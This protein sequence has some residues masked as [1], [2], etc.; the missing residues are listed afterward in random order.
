MSFDR[1]SEIYRFHDAFFPASGPTP[2][3][4]LTRSTKCNDGRTTK[5]IYVKDESV[6]Y[7]LPAFKILGASWGTAK[8]LAD[9]TGVNVLHFEALR[10]AARAAN[11]KVYAATDGNHGRAVARTASRLGLQAH[12]VVPR[13]VELWSQQAIAGEGCEVTVYD[14]DYDQAVKHAAEL[15]E[16]QGGLLVQDTSWDGYETIPRNI[17][18]G[19]TRLFAEI[20]DQLPSDIRP[21][22]VI[23]PVGVG[24]LALAAVLAYQNTSTEI[25]TV[26]P[27][28]AACLQRS[29]REGRNT[30][31]LTG[32][33]IMPG[34]NC[35]TV[36]EQAWPHLKAGIKADHTISITDEEARAAMQALEQ[37]GIRVGPCGAAPFAALKHAKLSPEAIVVLICTEGSQSSAIN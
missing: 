13:S 1:Y 6:R 4:Q 5:G 18:E 20:Q 15:A 16:A 24:S 11:L 21:T 26:E 28:T 27:S 37:Q 32:D 19:Y 14:G 34:L 31:I 33:T 25:I 8:A 23:V 10:A 9:R 30:P 17:V 35:G 22:H 2:L 7:G 36:S 12:I 3:V 29:L